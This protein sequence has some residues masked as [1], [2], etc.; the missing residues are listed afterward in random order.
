[1]IAGV[2]RVV[3]GVTEKRSE[4]VREAVGEDALALYQACIAEGRFL[5][6]PARSEAH[7]LSKPSQMD[8][9]G[10]ADNAGTENHYVRRSCADAPIRQCRRAASLHDDN[11]RDFM[12]D[13]S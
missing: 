12:G 3:Q 8:R 4:I 2:D 10:N 11:S 6:A 7:R 9:A 13:V 5:P 1:M